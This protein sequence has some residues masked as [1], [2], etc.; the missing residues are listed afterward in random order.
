MNIIEAIA[1]EIEPYEQSLASIEKSLIDAGTHFKAFMPT[2]EYSEEARKTVALASMMCLSKMLS[3]SSEN[4]GGF[5]QNYDTQR[6]EERIK[7][8]AK[9]VGISPNLVLED[10]EKDIICIHI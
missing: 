4:A 1:T 8:I 6:L 2:D 3:L 9:G 5:S 7:A 10:G